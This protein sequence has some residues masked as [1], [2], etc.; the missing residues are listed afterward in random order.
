MSL[1]IGALVLQVTRGQC[2]P[3]KG[4]FLWQQ[5]HTLADMDTHGYTWTHPECDAARVRVYTAHTQG[6]LKAVHSAVHMEP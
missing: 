1:C 5:G 6:A 4:E 3:D 2:K